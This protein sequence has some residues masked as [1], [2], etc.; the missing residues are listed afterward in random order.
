M[1][2]IIEGE[3]FHEI[4]EFGGKNMNISDSG[5]KEISLVK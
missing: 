1:R 2:K 5:I 3:L 4:E